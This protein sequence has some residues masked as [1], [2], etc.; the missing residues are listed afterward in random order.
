MN[1]Q[2]VSLRL[3]GSPLRSPMGRAGFRV[4]K[5]HKQI[6]TQGTLE[7]LTWALQRPKDATIQSKVK[8]HQVIGNAEK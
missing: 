5:I 3:T 7:P 4:D 6:N 2:A 1:M 8:Q